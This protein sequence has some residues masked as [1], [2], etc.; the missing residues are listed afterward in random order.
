MPSGFPAAKG[1]PLF[2]LLSLFTDDNSSWELSSDDF[3]ASEATGTVFDDVGKVG[4]NTSVLVAFEVFTFV[5][6]GPT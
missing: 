3:L 4:E 6:P 5:E 2:P 1:S